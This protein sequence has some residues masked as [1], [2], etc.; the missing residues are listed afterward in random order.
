MPIAPPSPAPAAATGTA[1]ILTTPTAPVTWMT[2]TLSGPITALTVMR[3]HHQSGIAL[4]NITLMESI[5]SIRPLRTIPSGIM[6]FLTIAAPLFGQI[7]IK[8]ICQIITLKAAALTV[9]IVILLP[10]I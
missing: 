4:L 3:P 7:N 10:V 5:V 2:A 9:F 1:C 8:L 6:N